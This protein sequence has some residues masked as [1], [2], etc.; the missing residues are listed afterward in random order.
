MDAPRHGEPHSVCA[1]GAELGE[2][3][4]WI[5]SDAALWFVDI[6]RCRIHR[7]DPLSGGRRDWLAP[8]QPGWVLAAEGGVLVVGLQTGV[9][10]VNP[11]TGN[12]ARIVAPEPERPGNR[13]NDAA[14]GPDGALWF[15]TMDDACVEPMGHIYRLAEGAL[16]RSNLPPAAIVNGPALSADGRTLYYVDT[17]ARRIWA[18]PIDSSGKL[19]APALLVEIEAEAGYPDGL[20]VDAE[21]HVWVA[22]FAGW[23]A[24]RYAPD[25]GLVD[26]IRFPVAHVTKLAF[27][28]A[29]GAATAAR[30]SITVR[31]AGGSA[32]RIWPFTRPPRPAS[33]AYRARARETSGQTASA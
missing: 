5:E 23:A 26:T 8:A 10:R 30:L 32:C 16:E 4:V 3:P 7:F 21:G 31:S 15:G 11:E 27:G 33:R 25:G 2:G 12:F 6:K 17:L 24:R 22:L 19:G 13:L 1:L 14:V 29:A 20:A 18:A 9:H 28:G